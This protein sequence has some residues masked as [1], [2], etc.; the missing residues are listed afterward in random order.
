MRKKNIPKR[1][2][3]SFLGVSLLVC[4]CNS[5][6]QNPEGELLLAKETF[7]TTNNAVAGLIR[8]GQVAEDEARHILKIAHTG[9]H[10]L[11]KWEEALTAGVNKPKEAAAFWT[12]LAELQTIEAKYTNDSN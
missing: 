9:Q 3:I 5:Q 7:A 6:Q 2:L 1:L 11:D 12:I 4:G 10:F 8:A